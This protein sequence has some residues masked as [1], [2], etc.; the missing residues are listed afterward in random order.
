M[1][2]NIIVFLTQHNDKS[3]T[4]CDTQY[5]KRAGAGKEWEG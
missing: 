5:T 4:S 1:G 3:D 2:G